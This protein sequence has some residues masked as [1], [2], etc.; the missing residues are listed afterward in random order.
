LVVQP[1]KGYDG[2]YLLAVS[3][4]ELVVAFFAVNVS[5]L[6]CWGSFFLSTFSV[7]HIKNFPFNL[8]HFYLLGLQFEKSPDPELPGHLL[9]EQYQVCHLLSY[10]NLL[11][12]DLANGWLTCT[13]QSLCVVDKTCVVE[14]YNN[15][16]C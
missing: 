13:V 3:C 4:H 6:H 14:Y 10:Y 16:H 9:L 8:F 7:W 15:F 11:G 1:S 2:L 5:A 12:I